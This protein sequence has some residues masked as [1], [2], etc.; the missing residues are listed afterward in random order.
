MITYNNR[1]AMKQRDIERDIKAILAEVDL[2]DELIDFDEDPEA[3]VMDLIVNEEDPKD[4][5]AE[6]DVVMYGC[7][8][9][10]KEEIELDVDVTT[11]DS[12]GYDIDVGEGP[13][14]SDEIYVILEEEEEHTISS[15]IGDVVLTKKSNQE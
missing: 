8:W 4:D 3:V 1:F 2:D 7:D 6:L 11:I 10:T 15:W 5:I 14:T 12:D 9:P 13:T